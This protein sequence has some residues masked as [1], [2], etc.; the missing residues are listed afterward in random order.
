MTK[1]ERIR[2][3]AKEIF[4]SSKHISKK[5]ALEFAKIKIG[6]KELEKSIKSITFRKSK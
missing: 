5:Q 1:N 6:Q 2:L 3:L 4:A